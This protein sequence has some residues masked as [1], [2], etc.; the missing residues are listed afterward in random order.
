MNIEYVDTMWHMN[1]SSV[2]TLAIAGI[3]ALIGYKIVERVGF[4]RKY[5]IPA[6]VVG[7]FIVMLINLLG[8][9]T[10][11][12]VIN[13]DNAYQSFFML[14]FFTTVGLGASFNLLKIGGKALIIYWLLS[15][16]LA[17]M[18]NT[19]GVTVGNAIGLDAAYSLLASAIPLVGGHGA[20]L[21]YGT[22]FQEMGYEAGP[23]VGAASATY[24]LISAVLIGGPLARHLIEK[25][26]LKPSGVL[27]TMHEDVLEVNQGE[28]T[29]TAFDI[30]ANVTMILLSMGLGQ[31]ISQW[32]GDLIGMQ[33]PEYVGAMLVAVIVRNVYDRFEFFNFNYDLIDRIGDVAL[34]LYLS[35]AM[36]S[37]ALWEL[38]GLFGGVIIV[39]VVNTIVTVLL[40]YFL[41]FKVLGKD[42]DAAVMIA[43]QIGHGLGATPTAMVN[44]NTITQRYGPSHKAYIIVPIV[45][46]FLVDIIYQPVT[47]WFISQ[48]VQ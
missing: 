17:V 40:V 36:I 38:S 24:G 12:F 45:G 31:I 15:S 11:T 37:M 16:F 28:K 34:N 6:P 4:L 8:H 48:F 7:G 2:L 21:S 26:R 43:G 22:T 41:S 30:L 3:M 27:E 35:M 14:A 20:A 10:N 25:Y 19:V 1:I 42:Y 13:F 47:I 39:L 44:M 32:I 46:A 18:Q 23:L 9:S 29:L 33:F 5:C